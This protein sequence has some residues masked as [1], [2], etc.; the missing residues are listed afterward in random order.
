MDSLSDQILLK[1]FCNGDRG[2][3]DTLFRRYAPRVHATA[4]RLTYHWEDAEDVLQEVF[5]RLAAKARTIRR[6][7][8]L[9]SWLYRTAVHCATDR[10]RRRRYAVSLDNPSVQ[11]GRIIA[12]ESLRREAL[13]RERRREQTLLARIEALIPRL[14]SRQAAVFVLRFFQGLPHRE[15]AAI[16]EI[17]ETSSKSHH[18]L[19]C[20][21]LRQWVAADERAESE[22]AD[23]TPAGGRGREAAR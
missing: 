10:L 1:R 5:L 11:T 14:P 15:I 6:G 2:A 22:G 23:A 4:W 13:Q 12:V 20:R 16:L 18:C 3:F 7:R 9:G 8:A 17:G 19:A 21:R